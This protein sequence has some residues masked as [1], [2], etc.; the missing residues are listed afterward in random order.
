MSETAVERQLPV[1]SCQLPE[2]RRRGFLRLADIGAVLRDP[3]SARGFTT[4]YLA[5]RFG[6]RLIDND[7]VKVIST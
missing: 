4:F 1:P 7:A 6:G 5:Q 2:E 3:F